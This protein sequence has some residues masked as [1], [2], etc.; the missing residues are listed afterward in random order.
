MYN[1]Y[2]LYSEKLSKYYIGQTNALN[3]RIHR[4]NSG[5]EKFT[6]KGMPWKLIWSTTKETRSEAMVL[7]RKLKNLSQNRLQ[8]FIKKY[9][10]EVANPDDTGMS[11]C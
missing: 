1:V 10:H 4:H 2:I 5:F 11:G 7:E 6:S 3:D 8:D 9:N